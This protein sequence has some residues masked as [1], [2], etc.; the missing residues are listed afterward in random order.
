MLT[1]PVDEIWVEAVPEYDGKQLQSIAKRQV[2]LPRTTTTPRSRRQSDFAPLLTCLAPRW[3][4]RSR[5]SACRTGSPRRRP[6]W[7]ATPTT[8]RPRWS[9][10]TGRWARRC[11]QVKRILELNPAHPLVTGLRDGARRT[12]RRPGPAGDGRAAVRH[13]PA[14]RGRRPGGPGPVRE[15]ARRPPDPHDLTLPAT[16]AALSPFR[17]SWSCGCLYVRSVWACANHNSRSKR[18][19]VSGPRRLRHRRTARRDD[20][21]WRPEGGRRRRR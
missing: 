7:S 19:R 12:R 17:R 11:P 15:A 6:A 3:T 10:C 1:D 13:G 8:S 4:S 16:P 9:G 5:R 18:S 14:R 2:D 21:A 20:E